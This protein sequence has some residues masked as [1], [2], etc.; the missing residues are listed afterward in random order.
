MHSTVLNVAN[1]LL[2]IATW[3]EVTYRQDGLLT[4]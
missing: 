1:I 3:Y 4:N 2:G